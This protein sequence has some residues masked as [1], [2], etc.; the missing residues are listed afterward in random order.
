MFVVRERTY[1]TETRFRP[2]RFLLY[3][4]YFARYTPRIQGLVIVTTLSRPRYPFKKIT[5]LWRGFASDRKQSYC[6]PCACSRSQTWHVYR[7]LQ[8]ERARIVYDSSSNTYC[9]KCNIMFSAPVDNESMHKC[10]ESL[11]LCNERVSRK[12]KCTFKLLR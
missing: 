11:S 12:K 3:T 10:H 4:V 8:L 6:A 1:A 5:F 7:L 9:I 2:S